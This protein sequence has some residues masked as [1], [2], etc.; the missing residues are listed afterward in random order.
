MSQRTFSVPPDF[1]SRAARTTYGDTPPF[2]SDTALLS[3][4]SAIDVLREEGITFGD[5][6]TAVFNASSSTLIVRN[7]PAM[8]GLVEQV[9]DRIQETS[10]DKIPRKVESEHQFTLDHDPLIDRR[11]LDSFATQEKIGRIIIPHLTLRDATLEQALAVIRPYIPEIEIRIDIGDIDIGP[12]ISIELKDVPVSE[13]LRY[14]TE[15]AGLKYKLEKDRI[16]ILPVSSISSD[17]YQRRYQVPASWTTELN[18]RLLTPIDVLKEQGIT[19]PDSAQATLE[20]TVLIVRNTGPMLDLVG[21][22]LIEVWNQSS[23][24]PP[25]PFNA[26]ADAFAASPAMGGLA[27]GSSPPAARSGLLPLDIPLPTAGRVLHLSGLQE[28]EDL[29][30]SFIAWQTLLLRAVAGI[31]IGLILFITLAR[32]RPILLT[33]WVVVLIGFLPLLLH[34]PWLAFTQA[35]IWGWFI[36]LGLAMLH[37]LFHLRSTSSTP[38]PSTTTLSAS[39]IS[40]SLILLI[41]LPTF[42]AEPAA[43]PAAESTSDPAAHTV[44]IPYATDAN[45]NS[46][47][48]QRYYL[49]YADF[50]T[51]WTRAKENRRP[52]APLPE[53]LTQAAHIHSLR[54]QIHIQPDHIRIQARAELVSRGQW[55]PLQLQVQYQPLPNNLPIPPFQS[56]TLTDLQINNQNTAHQNGHLVIEKPGQQNLSF[57]TVIPL[58]NP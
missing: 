39:T 14:I 13:A 56:A 34:G 31:A 55:S 53:D 24:Q 51:L 21:S 58:T 49:P 20:G 35:I 4:T 6:A 38:L 16:T 27:P 29:S 19:I 42:A 54:Y 32:R 8:L 48:P 9:V 1:L 28:P 3:R 23:E 40:S 36:G 10:P 17:L 57:S 25:L 18:R 11:R 15:L 22:Y 37:R 2:S 5:G 7:T 45:L 44:I 52:L 12:I 33:L 30:I 50:E 47:T 26:D 41:S 46:F 43:E